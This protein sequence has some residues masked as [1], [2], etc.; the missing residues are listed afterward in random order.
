MAKENIFDKTVS[1]YTTKFPLAQNPSIWIEVVGYE[2]L[3][4]YMK[5]A[6]ETGQPLEFSRL[7]PTTLD[8]YTVTMGGKPIE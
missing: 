3:L 5:L 8:G 6:I 4:T 7:E 1:E 2:P